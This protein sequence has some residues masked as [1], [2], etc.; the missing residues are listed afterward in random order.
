[1]LL[2]ALA[3][4][5]AVDRGVGV[6]RKLGAI[7]KNKYGDNPAVLAEWT[8]VSHTER[9]PKRRSTPTAPTTTAPATAPPTP[10]ATPSP[11]AAP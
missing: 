8:S 10:P 7:I 5:D 2:P 9:G 6:V 4:D 1:M 11:G 3:I